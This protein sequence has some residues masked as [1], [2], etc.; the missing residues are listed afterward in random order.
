MTVCGG[1]VV[2]GG[3]TRSSC[4]HTSPTTGGVSV[5]LGHMEVQNQIKL[6]IIVNCP[7]DRHHPD[8]IAFDNFEL[9]SSTFDIV[10]NC[11]GVL[12]HLDE[13]NNCQL[14]TTCTCRSSLQPL[15]PC[16][17]MPLWKYSW[18]LDQFKANYIALMSSEW[19]LGGADW[20][21]Q[22]WIDPHAC[23]FNCPGLNLAALL[24]RYRRKNSGP[25][26]PQ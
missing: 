17:Q 8:K 25:S 6:D 23:F 12:H 5:S 21:K 24:L 7:L 18:A 20:L 4:C 19:A 26:T 15:S 2:C 13:I 11:P 16:Q 1:L 9:S 14:S 3:S 22:L 10:V